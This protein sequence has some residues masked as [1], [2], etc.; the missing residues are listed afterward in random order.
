MKSVKIATTER[1]SEGVFRGSGSHNAA[2][3]DHVGARSAD[4][5][6]CGYARALERRRRRDAPPAGALELFTALH[7]RYVEGMLLCF[8][9]MGK[10]WYGTVRCGSLSNR[11]FYV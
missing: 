2:P 10:F 1:A 8:T 7:L 9:R 6:T 3:I 11:L 5:S 4:D